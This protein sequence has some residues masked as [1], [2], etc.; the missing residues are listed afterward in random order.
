MVQFQSTTREDKDKELDEL[1]YQ[2]HS[3]SVRDYAYAKAYAQC[4]RRF[5]DTMRGI[6]EP[7]YR[8]GPP[9]ATYSFQPATL[10][11]T[12]QPWSALAAAPAQMPAPQT[13]NANANTIASFFH[14]TPRIDGCSFCTAQD[15]QVCQC[16]IAKEY[17]LTGRASL[18]GE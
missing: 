1:I 10:P 3:L 8:D 7:G 11:P 14:T 13:A 4:T 6:P 17:V 16:A 5:P 2:L 15:H 9:T 18:V 12:Q